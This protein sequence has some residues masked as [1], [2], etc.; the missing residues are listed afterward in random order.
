MRVINASS[1][2][3]SL[4]FSRL[5]WFTLSL[6]C[7]WPICVDRFWGKILTWISDSLSGRKCLDLP[8][9]RYSNISPLFSSATLRWV[10]CIHLSPPS[11]TLSF[12]ICCDRFAWW[13]IRLE[14][15]PD[16]LMPISFE[17]SF[18]C[19]SHDKTNNIF[20][21]QHFWVAVR[22]SAIQILSLHLH[23]LSSP[24]TQSLNFDGDVSQGQASREFLCIF[25][26]TYNA[27]NT[28]LAIT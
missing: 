16:V 28:M 8:T 27:Y 7:C 12:L 25:Y 19:I 14:R 3:V 2:V 4:T 20:Y 24:L 10:F 15:T 21:T 1:L 17:M 26:T 5:P 23:S 18:V 22:R 9:Y 6:C 11:S 13:A